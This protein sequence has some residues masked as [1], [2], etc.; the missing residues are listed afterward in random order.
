[1][2]QTARALLLD[3]I[4]KEGVSVVGK[5]HH[6]IADN[7]KMMWGGKCCSSVKNI[8]E[9]FRRLERQGLFLEE[10]DGEGIQTGY[11][12][13]TDEEREAI[14]FQLRRQHEARE[15]PRIRRRKSRRGNYRGERQLK[16]RNTRFA[17]ADGV[18]A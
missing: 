10:F 11:R 15:L 6:E 1:M 12:T 2:A 7:L 18:F 17:D 14:V 9:E 5:N 13:Q 8:R 3:L 4:K 16:E